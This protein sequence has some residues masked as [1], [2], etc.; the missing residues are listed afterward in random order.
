MRLPST[1]RPAVEWEGEYWER[2]KEQTPVSVDLAR[3][4]IYWLPVAHVREDNPRVNPIVRCPGRCVPSLARVP[5][6]QFG[7]GLYTH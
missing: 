6:R 7:I 5:G 1:T 4:A 2:R 3:W